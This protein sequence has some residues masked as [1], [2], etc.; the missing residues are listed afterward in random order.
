MEGY[1]HNYKLYKENVFFP[2][3]FLLTKILS[4][5]ITHRNKVI[6]QV[7]SIAKKSLFFQVTQDADHQMPSKA[8][9]MDIKEDSLYNIRSQKYSFQLPGE[10]ADVLTGRS[11]IV[12]RRDQGEG[13]DETAR[14]RELGVG[15]GRNLKDARSIF[16]LGIT[17][18]ISFV[19]DCS[20]CKRWRVS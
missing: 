16:Y 13:Q 10:G 14:K 17:W 18:G 1:S 7:N 3:V 20:F 8:N 11:V 6:S 12:L 19:V 2:P 15:V 9:L 4:K 5:G